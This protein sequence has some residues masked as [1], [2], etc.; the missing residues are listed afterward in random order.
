MIKFIK[1]LLINKNIMLS[2]NEMNDLVDVD[3][4][5]DDEN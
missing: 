5:K 3:F 2:L 1:F 4:L